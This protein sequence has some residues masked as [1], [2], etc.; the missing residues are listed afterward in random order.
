[1]GM[2]V[3]HMNLHKTFS[4]PHGGGGPGAGP[5]AV[6]EQLEPYLPKPLVTKRLA[7]AG[8]VI[9]PGPVCPKPDYYLDYERPQSIGRVK[10]FHGN[11]GVLVRAYSYVLRMGADGLTRA[12]EDAVIN[13]NYIRARIRDVYEVPH[14]RYNMHEFV[15]SA[16]RQK[17]RGVPAAAIAKRIL[18]FGMHAPTVYFPLIVPE[19]LMIEPTESE[20]LGALDAFVDV[21]RQID[22]ETRETPAVVLDAP[23]ST[24]CRRPDEVRAAREPV[25]R[26]RP[27]GRS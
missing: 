19:A 1:M 9:G 18:D 25:L 13:A 15:A 10:G 24:P 2:D 14:D 11:I 26:W 12:S 21:L 17:K 3:V 8:R 4:T 20:D 27:G 7:P 23:H 6:G 5:V 16:G 22:R